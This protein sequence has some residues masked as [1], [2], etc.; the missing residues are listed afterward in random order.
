M[1]NIKKISNDFFEVGNGG[2]EGRDEVGDCHLH[3]FLHSPYEPGLSV[4]F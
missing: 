4:W 3:I 2:G 1:I